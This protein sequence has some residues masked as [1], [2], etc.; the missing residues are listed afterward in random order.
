MYWETRTSGT[1][2]GLGSVNCPADRAPVCVVVGDRGQILTTPLGRMRHTATLLPN[3]DVLVV[4]GVGPLSYPAAGEPTSSQAL[5]SAE[6]YNSVSGEWTATLGALAVKR[7]SHTASLLGDGRVLVAGGVSSLDGAT[8]GA[9][10]FTAGV[11]L[12]DPSTGRWKATGSLKTARGEHSATVLRNGQVLVA[13]RGFGVAP[14][15]G[16]PLDAAELYDPAAGA[17]TPTASMITARG[18]HGATLL[19]GPFCRRPAPP[20]SCGRVLVEGG[21]GP[22]YAPGQPE[23]GPPPLSLGELYVPAPSVGSVSPSSGPTTGGTRVRIAGA[24]FV[25]G[26]TVTFDGR[27]ATSIRVDSATL[28]TA[29]APPHSSGGVQVVV[30]SGSAE[31]ATIVPALA[32]LFTYNTCGVPPM[33]GQIAYPA[34]QYSLVGLPGNVSVPSTSYRYG[35]VNRASGAYDVFDPALTR[36]ESGHGYWA[37]FACSVPI[38]ITGPESAPS[39]ATSSPLAARPGNGRG[40]QYRTVG[41]T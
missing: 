14:A 34:G 1:S 12:F 9:P 35:W 26:S 21:A 30:T 16:Y 28:L 22:G 20:D 5:S 36:T 25:A 24:G 29:V 41:G 13:G 17:W 39:E 33:G 19:D 3:G 37:Y 7:F 4:G 8:A 11:E 10:I 38:D 18:M 2:D 15:P 27:P 31:S 23:G 32:G 6:V 40:S